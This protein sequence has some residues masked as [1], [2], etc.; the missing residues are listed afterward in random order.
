MNFSC[1]Q[2]CFLADV[3]FLHQPRHFRHFRE[4]FQQSRQCGRPIQG[5]WSSGS[6]QILRD[7]FS[8]KA[9]TNV[10]R[11]DSGFSK[12]ASERLRECQL[13]LVGFLFIYYTFFDAQPFDL[14][15]FSS[16]REVIVRKSGMEVAEHSGVW[17][18]SRV[19]GELLKATGRYC[20]RFC[21]EFPNNVHLL[22]QNLGKV[23]LLLGYF[24]GLL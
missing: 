24:M 23:E 16:T 6:F 10:M 21:G 17:P 9:T 1:S 19:K 18:K 15:H 2:P 7:H 4:Q 5:Q 12:N 3:F 22:L 13:W 11:A 8:A 20:G 14:Q